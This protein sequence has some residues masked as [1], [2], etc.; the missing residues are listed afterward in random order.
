MDSSQE[1]TPSA[2]KPVELAVWKIDRFAIHDGPGIRTNL[3][4][5]GCPLRC[6]WCSNPEGQQGG[7]ELAFLETRCTSCGQCLDVCPEG[8]IRLQLDKPVVDFQMCNSCGQCISACPTHALFFYKNNYTFYQVMDIIK[9]DSYIYRRSGGGI[10]CTG[11]EPFLQAKGLQLL[12]VKCHELGIHNCV[13]TCGYADE[14]QFRGVLTNIDLLFFDLK[15]I[16]STQHRK[17]T[18]QDNAIILSNLKM[19][20]SIFAETGRVLVIR[21]VVVPGLND[22][23]NIRAVAELARELPYVEMIELLPYHTYGSYKYQALGRQYQLNNL[24][25]PSDDEMLAYKKMV[26]SYGI[27]CEIGGS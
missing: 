5:K 12:L 25:P 16:D 7:S 15:H 2:A 20:S 3:Y 4:F 18:G 11:G 6:L 24:D 10:T 21:K 19:V 8:A 13:E 17:L 22:G 14:A 27:R 1:T 9:R 23:S 26:E